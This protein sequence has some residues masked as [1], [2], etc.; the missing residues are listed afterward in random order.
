MVQGPMKDEHRYPDAQA[1]HRSSSPLTFIRGLPLFKCTAKFSRSLSFDND[2]RVVSRRLYRP[3]QYGRIQI[4]TGDRCSSLGLADD[5]RGDAWLLLK[6]RLDVAGACCAVEP[7]QLQF[8]RVGFVAVHDA[9]IIVLKGQTGL[10]APQGWFC[11]WSGLY[12]V[13]DDVA[14][15]H[16]TND[17]PARGA[18]PA[19]GS[20]HSCWGPHVD[21]PDGDATT[22]GSFNGCLW[23]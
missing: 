6:G 9:A 15:L 12:C 17:G 11:G 2:V 18:S 19:G 5:N 16:I 8:M 7:I 22:G 14:N 23:R 3:Y 4:M 20:G 13:L 10:V 21:G 1:D